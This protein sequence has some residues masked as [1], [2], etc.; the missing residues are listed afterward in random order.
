[1]TKSPVLNNTH[2][3]SNVVLSTRNGTEF[4]RSKK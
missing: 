1:M 4:K 3:S 2:G